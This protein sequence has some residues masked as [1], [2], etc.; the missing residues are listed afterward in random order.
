MLWKLILFFPGS[1]KEEEVVPWNV[2]P[3]FYSF[4]KTVSVIANR[5]KYKPTSAQNVLFYT[6][7]NHKHHQKGLWTDLIV[8]W[9]YAPYYRILGK[10][11]LAGNPVHSRLGSSYSMLPWAGFQT[12]K[13]HWCEHSLHHSAIWTPI[14]LCYYYSA[15]Y[16]HTKR[17][18]FFR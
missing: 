12:H 2:C 13:P 4:R 15:L 6:L 17:Q 9:K 3:I 14:Y 11:A 10:E 1:K 7:N 8:V 16:Q 18:L 5:N